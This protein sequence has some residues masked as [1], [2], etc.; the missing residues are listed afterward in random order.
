MPAHAQRCDRRAERAQRVARVAGQHGVELILPADEQAKHPPGR[1]P[2]PWREG[3]GADADLMVVLGGDGTTLRALAA[4]IVTQVPVLAINHGRVGFLTTAPE[5][6]LETA[7]E[8]A[9]AG[10]FRVQELP[11]I[12]VARGGRRLGLAVNDAVVTSDLHGRMAGFAWSVQGVALGEIGCDAMV[13]STPTGSTAYNLSAGGPVIGMGARGDAGH[14]RR[15]ALAAGA[16]ARASAR[17]GG[18]IENVSEAGD[19]RVVID[20]H[21][22]HRALA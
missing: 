12:A 20:G 14:V 8:R 13:V 9:F 15:P 1:L 18:E 5:G 19:A 16:L 21:L 2:C 11:T 3:D 7:L 17:R 4:S 10:E 22:E 6:E